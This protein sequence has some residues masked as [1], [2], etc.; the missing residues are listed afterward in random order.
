MCLIAYASYSNIKYNK[1]LSFKQVCA[2]CSHIL[3]Q[4]TSTK[5]MKVQIIRRL[6][7]KMQPT[8][9]TIMGSK[10]PPKISTAPVQS[11]I[12]GMQ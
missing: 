10:S 1:M 6:K 5:T 7:S 4:N 8:K 2:V 9:N 11:V 12:L 3:T